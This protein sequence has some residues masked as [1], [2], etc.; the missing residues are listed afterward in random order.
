MDLSSRAPVSIQYLRTV[1]DDQVAL[2]DL[3]TRLQYINAWA[4]D[5]DLSDEILSAALAEEWEPETL[6]EV[7]PLVG[8]HREVSCEGCHQAQDFAALSAACTDCHEETRPAPHFPGTCSIC[9]S[10][11]SWESAAFVHEGVPDLDCANCH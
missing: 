10:D 1:I 2:A 9:H 5:P 4:V 6:H 3:G 8:A 11:E 7:F